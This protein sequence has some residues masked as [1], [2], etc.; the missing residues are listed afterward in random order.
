MSSLFADIAPLER[1]LDYHLERQNVLN[2]NVA[3][4]NTPGFKAQ[5]LV[6]PASQAEGQLALAAMSSGHL[7]A[8]GSAG[9]GTIQE[10]THGHSGI[11]G[12][13]VSLEREMSKM[14]ANSLR[15]DAATEVVSRRLAMLRYAATDGQ[16]S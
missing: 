9:V 5:D 3:N 15:Y 12:N 4:L 8:A 13:T 6:Q 16:S 2:S 11:D 7:G 14:M 10:D 1:A